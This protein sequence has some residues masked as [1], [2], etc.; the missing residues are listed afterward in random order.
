MHIENKG[1]ESL[2]PLIVLIISI[3]LIVFI[4]TKILSYGYMPSDDALRHCA[5]VISKKP[6]SEILVLRKDIL[7]DPHIGWHK[8]LSLFH[9]ITKCD[10]EELLIF[11]VVFLF[12]IFTVVPIFF[13][14][15]HEAYLLAL[16]IAFLVER[17]LLYRIL[18]G[19]P[20]IFS[21]AAIMFIL[22]LW[23]KYKENIPKIVYILTVL[24]IAI[25]IYIHTL[26]WFIHLILLSGSFLL[27]KEYKK[28]VKLGISISI[29]IIIAAILTTKPLYFFYQ[30]IMLNTKCLN[31]ESTR[32]LVTE[33]QP[34]LGNTLLITTI[35]ILLIWSFLR[36]DFNIKK[37]YNPVFIFM[38][39]SW[40]LGFYVIRFWI[41]FGVVGF[42]VW[43]IKEFEEICSKYINENSL[44]RVGIVFVTAFTIFLMTTSDISSRWSAPLFKIRL[45]KD[46]KNY[47]DWMPEDGGI[48]YSASMGIFYDTFY[49]N[50]KANWRYVLG[51]EP[52]LMPEEDLKIYRNI[53][54][55]FGAFEAYKEWVKKLRPQDRLIIVTSKNPK[56]DIKELE[57][58]E[59]IPNVF[60][61]RL[62]KEKKQENPSNNTSNK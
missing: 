22:F 21:M 24:I 43:L 2:I 41:D 26:S 48:I 14:K 8:L 15:R 47:S 38:G 1:N 58:K 57:W 60:I 55:T 44:K 32:M 25:D 50:P 42:L 61:G 33:F 51:F 49:E 37:V 29:G 59:A 45:H 12:T 18:F 56:D 52:S 39:I 53:Q 20:F 35:S 16:L 4:P 28:A 7:I 23:T 10:I 40:I 62:P 6:W 34:A 30:T 27:A 36:K 5:K 17:E 13:T 31:A 9:K 46:N 19:R 11:S 3:I 54:Y